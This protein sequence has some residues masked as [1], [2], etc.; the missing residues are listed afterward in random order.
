MRFTVLIVLLSLIAGCSSSP[1]L[2]MSGQRKGGEAIS[3]HSNTTVHPLF[4]HPLPWPVTGGTVVKEFGE[5]THAQLGTVTENPGIDIAVPHGTQVRSVASGRIS[6]IDAIPGF[7]N[8]VIVEHDNRFTEAFPGDSSSVGARF[9]AC[10]VFS[11]NSAFTIAC[12]PKH[13]TN[14]TGPLVKERSEG[15][16]TEPL[17]LLDVRFLRHCRCE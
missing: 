2:S 8:V 4:T 5:Q 11:A 12:P 10:S 16:T 15:G 17:R 1:D 3:S 14:C 6:L 7:G 13:R 9:S